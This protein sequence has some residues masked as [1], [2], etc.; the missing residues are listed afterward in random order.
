MLLTTEVK[1]DTLAAIRQDFAQKSQTEKYTQ[2]RHA[3]ALGI[4]KSIY[5][6]LGKGETDKV[7]SDGEWIR[8]AVMLNVP[9]VT[10]G[11]K[12]AKTKTF[13]MI[14]AQLQECMVKSEG[15]IFCDDSSLGK[16]FAC[17]TFARQYA[18]VA[19]VDCSQ[20]STWGDLLR[21]IC[22]AFGLPILK[23]LA[24]TRSV[25][26]SSVL[27]LEKPLVIL[28]EAGDLND[29]AMLKLKGLSNALEYMCGWYVTGANGLRAKFDN[30]LSWNKVGWE[31]MFNRLGNK[32]QSVTEG[33]TRTETELFKRKQIEQIAIAQ[34]PK[35][36]PEQVANIVSNCEGNARRVR[37]ELMKIAA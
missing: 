8:I 25:L 30:K 22:T 24:E 12:V 19:Y 5:S 15:C 3:G 21:A 2:S 33:M 9:A 28:D 20:I 18:N 6:R 14:T 16:T 4:N 37:R 1:H 31:E 13:R 27:E 29:N 26:I 36:I 32:Y 10:G 35:L 23:T 34:N 7:L 11:W 17:K